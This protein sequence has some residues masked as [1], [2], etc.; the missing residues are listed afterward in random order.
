MPLPRTLVYNDLS[1]DEVKHILAERFATLLSEVPYLQKHLTLPRVKM[2]LNVVLEVW[3]DQA[4]PETKQIMDQVEIRGE[5]MELS[6]TIDASRNGQPPDLIREQYGLGIPTPEPQRIGGIRR[7]EDTVEN[8]RITMDNGVI[9]DR[10]GS[11]EEARSGSTV[12]KQD[13]GPA[14]EGRRL[15]NFANQQRASNPAPPNF[16]RFQGESE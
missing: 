13:F 15:M 1:G 9:I 2:H 7:T 4:T 8:R 3:A 12:V 10:T 14:R 16:N 6:T 5:A 11:S